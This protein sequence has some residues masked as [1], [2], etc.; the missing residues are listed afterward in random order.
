MGSSMDYSSPP[1]GPNQINN[2][3]FV[4]PVKI[5]AWCIDHQ[6]TL[7]IQCCYGVYS[8][9]K[10]FSCQNLVARWRPLWNHRRMEFELILLHF[11][12]IQMPT[13]ACLVGN[14][15]M[16]GWNSVNMS[17][18]GVFYWAG[19]LKVGSVRWPKI[20]IFPSFLLH[21]LIPIEFI[22]SFPRSPDSIYWTPWSN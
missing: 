10:Y 17:K 6:G 12:T 9:V 8:R 5:S 22:S 13:C 1:P 2:E 16:L 7:Y 21:Q 18:I 15:I 3:E 20:F 19:C 14:W 4:L 11:Y